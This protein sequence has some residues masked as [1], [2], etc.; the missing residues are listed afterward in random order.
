[1]LKVTLSLF[2]AL[3]QI[4]TTPDPV[5]LREGLIAHYSFNNCDATDD[6]GNDSNGVLFGD[7]GC[8]CGIEDDG[9]L[10][11]GVDDYLVF[12]GTV[13]DYFTT[14]DFT[15]SFYIRPEKNSV[16]RQS[17]LSKRMECDLNN[18]FD[19]SL[20]M[21]TQIM[22]TKIYETPNKYYPELS[23]EITSNGW[24]QIT[25]V[26][27]G[28]R[29]R[30]YINGELQREGFRCSGVDITNGALLSFSNTPCLENGSIRRF[31]GVLDELRVYERA[32]SEE[33]VKM[34]YELNPVENASMDCYAFDVK[35]IQIDHLIP[36]ESPYFCL[37]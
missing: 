7:M 36:S 21:N 16:F 4:L 17:L 8:W 30:T 28:L 5:N 23:P 33:E 14:S 27:E 37:A 20:N 35:K 2:F 25:L 9:L 22:D 34:L 12:N 26:R 24:F 18:M 10:F 19:L 31:K 29:A 6:S 1:M 13:N 3:A 11:D 15:I 32:L